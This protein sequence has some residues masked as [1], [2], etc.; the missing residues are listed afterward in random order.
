MELKKNP[1]LYG[2]WALVVLGVGALVFTKKIEW[3]VAAGFLVA[4][5]LPSLLGAAS[6]AKKE[7]ES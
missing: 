4:L 2:L 6:A 3:S 5:G 1:Y 7:G